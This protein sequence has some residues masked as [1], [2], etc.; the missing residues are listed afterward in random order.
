M[1][2]CSLPAHFQETQTL[3]FPSLSLCS[4]LL[5]LHLTSH[6]PSG[7]SGRT[8]FYLC[9]RQVHQESNTLFTLP[10]ISEGK[11]VS[12][13]NLVPLLSLAPAHNATGAASS[14]SS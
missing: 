8:V 11:K 7:R 12:K 3:L 9:V 5:L 2:V 10:D 13:R 1:A 4:I 6:S 14:H